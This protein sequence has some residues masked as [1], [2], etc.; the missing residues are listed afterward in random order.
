MRQK[1]FFS[2]EKEKNHPPQPPS[3]LDLL[4]NPSRKTLP[5]MARA[6]ILNFHFFDL[7]KP[8]ISQE[9]YSAAATARAI[10]SV[11]TNSTH[12][13]HSALPLPEE[14]FLGG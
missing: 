6:D 2:K 3:R 4:R 11:S 5:N 8:I 10:T 12:A 13:N 9:S 1:T 14:R 7:I